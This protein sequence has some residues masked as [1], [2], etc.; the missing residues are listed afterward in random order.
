MTTQSTPSKAERREHRF[1]L[2]HWLIGNSVRNG[3]RRCMHTGRASAEVRLRV[4]REG[5]PHVAG[6]ERCASWSCPV[7]APV[8]GERRAS[9]IDQGVSAAL[10][11]G[12]YV[13]FVTATVSH[14]LNDDLED[15]RA[16]V[17]DSWRST[18][19]GRAAAAWRLESG[20]VGQIRASEATYGVNGWHPHIHA[21]LIFR[22]PVTGLRAVGSAFAQH[23][24]ARGGVCLWRG[25]G[26]DWSPVRSSADLGGYLT[27][28][29]GGWG[30]GLEL[31]RSDLKSARRKGLQPF[32][33][34]EMAAGGDAR[35]HWLWSLYERVTFGKRR[36]VWS[37]G[38]KALLG[39]AEVSDDE[40]AVGEEPA[41]GLD[42]AVPGPVWDRM[43]LCG[44]LGGFL[45]RMG[46]IAVNVERSPN[47]GFDSGENTLTACGPPGRTLVLA[48]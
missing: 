9:E 37:R 31:A 24:A 29:E 27:K 25:P 20:Y 13:Y 4:S 14:Q 39:V 23:V 5:V 2:H 38:L 41:E 19:S 35:A 3:A 46:E 8:M 40:A 34:L 44:E 6:V 36:L 48:S 11:L 17:H 12:L 10:G 26:W 15:V 33:L 28:V 18:F 43:R 7:C 22:R 1:R 47:H 16:L 21:L 45:R 30:A 42:L 32:D